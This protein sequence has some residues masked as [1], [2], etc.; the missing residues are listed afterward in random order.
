MNRAGLTL[1]RNSLEAR[2]QFASEPPQAN[3]FFSVHTSRAG[4][5]FARIS[6]RGVQGVEGSQTR[7]VSRFRLQAIQGFADRY[8]RGPAL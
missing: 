5:R 2:V 4:L 7:S 3:G 6:H 1:S 8:C